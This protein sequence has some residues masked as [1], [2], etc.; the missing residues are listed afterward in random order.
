VEEGNFGSSCFDRLEEGSDKGGVDGVSSAGSGIADKR[1]E[2]S[3]GWIR[4]EP[5][6]LTWCFA[7]EGTRPL[8]WEMPAPIAIDVCTHRTKGEEW[9]M[10][11][12][13]RFRF[14]GNCSGVLPLAPLCLT[15]PS[16][17]SLALKMPPIRAPNARACVQ[18]P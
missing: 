3:N 16:S 10:I 11:L 7:T 17:S 13:F 8:N 15:S 18:P 6:Y 4:G 5:E 12:C 2:L 9:M 1:G 14:R